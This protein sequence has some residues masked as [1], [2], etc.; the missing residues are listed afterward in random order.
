MAQ[1]EYVYG[2]TSQRSKYHFLT[3]NGKALC[4]AD[5]PISQNACKHIKENKICHQCWNTDYDES[6]LLLKE[7]QSR[8]PKLP[9]KKNRGVPKGIRLL[10]WDVTFGREKGVADCEV[11]GDEITMG[12]FEAGHVTSHS[13]GGSLSIDNLRC[14]CHCCNIG[15]EDVNLE[16]YKILA[17][18]IMERKRNIQSW[19]PPIFIWCIGSCWD[20]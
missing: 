3:K 8:R 18:A 16:D 5:L 12:S 10:L 17:L 15:M 20:F 1:L 2:Q 4:N 6:I 13:D 9:N 11:C 7:I 14:I 19:I